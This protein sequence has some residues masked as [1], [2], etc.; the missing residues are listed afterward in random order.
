MIIRTPTFCRDDV[1]SSD[2]PHPLLTSRTPSR[3]PI[4]NSQ[5][6]LTSSK[7]SIRSSSFSPSSSRSSSLSASLKSSF[8]P[9]S[10]YSSLEAAPRALPLDFPFPA[11]SLSTRHHSTD[12]VRD[13]DGTGLLFKY[14]DRF[15]FDSFLDVRIQS[16]SKLKRLSRV[17]T[18]NP[19]I[20]DQKYNLL[21]SNLFY[22]KSYI[23][24]K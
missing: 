20:I 3:H 19:F 8:S 1:I 14:N 23:Y 15:K 12:G 6:T 16:P 4:N 24:I 22:T 21:P 13:W 10:S 11:D 9:S 7:S 18:L 2:T 5:G 17:S